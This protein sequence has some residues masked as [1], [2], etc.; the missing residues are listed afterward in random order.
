MTSSF[1]PYCFI[2]VLYCCCCL[3]AAHFNFTALDCATQCISFGAWCISPPHLSLHCTTPECSTTLLHS[4]DPE[5]TGSHPGC[6]GPGR[7][8]IGGKTLVSTGFS[9][10]SQSTLLYQ[11]VQHCIVPYNTALNSSIVLVS[12]LLYSTALPRAISHHRL[13]GVFHLSTP[14]TCLRIRAVK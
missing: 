13:R 9:D 2:S 10:T 1:K 4:D 11:S 6:W 5:I 12:T 8:V 3:T 14:V 7:L